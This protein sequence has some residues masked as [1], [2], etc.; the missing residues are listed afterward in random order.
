MLVL[1][2][3]DA[4]D[5]ES[6]RIFLAFFEIYKI[7][8]PLHRSKSR[9]F[10]NFAN[11]FSVIFVINFGKFAFSS[12]ILPFFERIL[13]KICRDFT[14]FQQNMISDQILRDP[15]HPRTLAKSG[16]YQTSDFDFAPR[17]NYA[18]RNLLRF[19]QNFENSEKNVKIFAEFRK[20]LQN[21]ASSS[22]KM[23]FL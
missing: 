10:E 8:I 14:K 12:E 5:C 23:I 15:K 17:P 4:S 16:L 11:I 22:E 13:M 7:C 2:C 3:I 21:F 18:A 1:F 9:K 6:R 19:L 20:F